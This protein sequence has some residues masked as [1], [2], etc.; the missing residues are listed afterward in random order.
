MWRIEGHNARW[1]SRQLEATLDISRPDVG[2]RRIR[3]GGAL[4]ERLS[5]L[6]MHLSSSAAA[7]QPV[8]DCYVRGPDLIV[9]YAETSVRPTRPQVYWRVIDEQDA[10]NIIM[11]EGI[12][13][14]QTEMLDMDPSVCVSCDV[15]GNTWLCHENRESREEP[16]TSSFRPV[17]LEH[18]LRVPIP[19][20]P[21]GCALLARFPELEW[22]FGQILLPSDLL[23][24]ELIG[25]PLEQTSRVRLQL[26]ADRLEK[27]VLRRA[28]A[29]TILVDRSRDESVIADYLWRMAQTAPPL[30]T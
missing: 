3:C 15:P 18:D 24:A 4:V 21:G 22:T 27:G 19:V 14:N 1:K 9:T 29:D 6:Q 20:P 11:L 30:T 16:S 25:N 12:I 28:R 2:L 7:C 17:S 10:S 23:G 13:S 8:E 5:L 26:F